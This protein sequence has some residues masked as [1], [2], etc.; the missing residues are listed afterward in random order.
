MAAGHGASPT[1]SGDDAAPKPS[2][3][4]RPL[5]SIV[6]PVYLAEALVEPL[7]ERIVAAVSTITSDFEIVLVEDGSPD[8]SWAMIEKQAAADPRVKGIQ[9]SRNFGQ[10]HALTAGLANAAGEYVV[11][12]DCDLQDDPADIPALFEAIQN[13]VDIVYTRKRERRHNGRRNWT[14]AAYTSLLNW[15][16]SDSHYKDD[17]GIGN[18]SILNR[19]VVDAFVGLRDTHRHYLGLLRWLGFRSTVLEIDHHERL[20]GKSS[21]TFKR[22]IREAFVGIT[23]QS[24]RLLRL[25]I[26]GGFAFVGLAF[27]AALGI[28]ALYFTNGFLRGWTSLVVLN[29]LGVGV[30]LM[31]LGVL[32]IYVGNIFEQSRERPLYLIRHT[33]NMDGRPGELPDGPPT[34]ERSLPDHDVVVNVVDGWHDEPS[35]LTRS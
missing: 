16:I 32:G 8:Q 13:D 1:S 9:L 15:L 14:G 31:S 21:Y 20:S 19:T 6:S 5:L 17:K 24:E 35:G 12:M 30:I 4:P 18:Y 25:S 2:P 7:V 28:V 22:L 3:D 11:V 10:H 26:I 27:G 29:L 33:V 23:S 34:A